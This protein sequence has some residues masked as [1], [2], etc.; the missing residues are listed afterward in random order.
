[1]NIDRKFKITAVNPCKP[2]KVYTE[3]EGIFFTAKD[4]ALIPALIAYANECCK[5]GANK[6]HI[7]SIDLLIG[8]VSDYQKTINKKVPDT[9]TDCEIARC[10]GAIGIED[11]KT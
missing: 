5:L 7:E 4:A 10:I 1:M 3:N 9:E 8:R 6:E 2:E 11:T